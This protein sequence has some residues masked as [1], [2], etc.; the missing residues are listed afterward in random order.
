MKDLGAA[1]IG[2]VAPDQIKNYGNIARTD[3][4]GA[5]LVLLVG[6]SPT[7]QEQVCETNQESRLC[8]IMTEEP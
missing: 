1:L 2:S 8:L 5:D 7:L 4:V 6:T 3:H